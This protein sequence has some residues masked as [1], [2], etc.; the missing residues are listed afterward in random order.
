MK[1]KSI[2]IAC[3]LGGIF[4]FNLSAQTDQKAAEITVF[5]SVLNTAKWAGFPYQETLNQAK[6]GDHKATVKL[7][8]FSGT[9]DGSSALDHSVTLLELLGSGIDNTFAAAL[10]MSKPKMRSVILD[11]LKLAQARTQNVALR[12]PISKWAPVTWGVLNGKPYA[13]KNDTSGLMKSPD[14]ATP[15]KSGTDPN[16]IS[17]PGAGASPSKQAKNKQ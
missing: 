7:L 14:G 8:D 9:V 6:K 10:H 3:F 1:V 12:E 13:P 2:L 4:S 17:A 15:A 16:A 11:R 5:E